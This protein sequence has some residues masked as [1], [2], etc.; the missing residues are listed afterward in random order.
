MRSE[1]PTRFSA[2]E[3]HDR[4]GGRRRLDGRSRVRQRAQS[5][6]G[7]EAPHENSRDD[8]EA[9]RSRIRG[10]RA[11]PPRWRRSCSGRGS[12]EPECC[13]PGTIAALT[14]FKIDE[15][16]PG[17]LAVA[18]RSRTGAARRS[19]ARVVYERRSAELDGSRT[20]NSARIGA[21]LRAYVAAGRRPVEHARRVPI[22]SEQRAARRWNPVAIPIGA[23]AGGASAA[24]V[25]KRR[26]GGAAW[27]SACA[28]NPTSRPSR[29]V[30]S[31]ECR[32]GHSRAGRRRV[33]PCRV[34]RSACS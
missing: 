33:D 23:R 30:C 34:R 13:S 22:A 5:G 28:W 20:S 16:L 32:R 17:S 11:D 7:R 1:R 27:L 10:E 4:A 18:L 15:N 31:I 21:W 14:R 2:V 12:A 29:A 6:R 19:C 26:G 8:R 24:A 9:R 25:V 3:D